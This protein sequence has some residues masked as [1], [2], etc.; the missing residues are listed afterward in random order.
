[1]LP[2][3]LDEVIL[4]C[5]DK[6]ESGR[7]FFE[8]LTEMLKVH[9]YANPVSIKN[10]LKKLKEAGKIEMCDGR[11]WN[12]VRLVQSGTADNATVEN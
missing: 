1:M 9:G 10:T 5:F 11:T 7:I 4:E 6:S 8:N 2:K 12:E 3:K